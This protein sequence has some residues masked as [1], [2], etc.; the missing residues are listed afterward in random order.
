LI[1]NFAEPTSLVSVTAAAGIALDAAKNLAAE[2]ATS[3]QCLG[4]AVAMNSNETSEW[5]ELFLNN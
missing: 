1:A 2:H 4:N 3:V 5:E